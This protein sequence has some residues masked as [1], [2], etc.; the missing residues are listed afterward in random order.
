MPKKLLAFLMLI[1]AVFLC[2]PVFAQSG[3]TSIPGGIRVKLSSG[4]TLQVT[5][6]G[7]SVIHVQ[8][9]HDILNAQKS[10]MVM[11]SNTKAD[12]S[13]T[14][15]QGHVSVKTSAVEAVV[16]LADGSIIF[17]DAA[18][19]LL[20]AATKS[21]FT[22]V[23]NGGETSWQ[24]QQYFTSSPTEA[25][26]GL[27]QHQEGL[28]NYKGY[29]VNLSQYNTDVAIPFMVSNKNYG[30]LWDN[31]SITKVGDVRAYQPL[32]GLKL[33]SKT[34]DEGWLT[35]SYVSLNDSTKVFVQR[36]ES[37]LDYAFL[38]DQDKF[39]AGVKLGDSRVIYEGSLASGYAGV[40]KFHL[41]YSGYIKIWVDGKLVANKWRQAWNPG[42]QIFEVNFQKDKTQPVRIEWI[43]DGG[44]AYLALNWLPPL[45]AKE[46]NEMAFSSEAGDLI[47]YYFIAGANADEVISGY[48]T[49]TGKATL[50]PKWA[51]GFW[52]SRERYKTQDEILSTIKEFRKR[53]I[54]IDNIVLDWSYWK[55]DQW[56]SQEFDETRFPDATGMIKS[57]HND[58]HAHFM[59]SVWP[60]F[61]KGTANYD[62][63]NS[64]GLLYKRNIADARRDWIGKGYE[65]TF[66]DAY[67]PQARAEV[68]S[69]MNKHLYSKG[70]DA[71]WMDASE[72]DLHSNLDVETRKT[73]FTPTYL[74]S[75]TKYFNA[76]A[77]ENAHGIY[78]GQR[79]T[80]PSARVFTLT[81]SA[82]G[83]M[84]RYAAATWSG[85]IASR[86]EDLK[87][88]IPAGLNFSLSGMPYWTMDIGGFSV[89]RRYE[90]P[91]AENLDEW[92]ELNTRW[93]Q[94]GAFVPLFR[95]HG[96]YPFREIYN[97]A[98]EGH[99]AYKSMLYYNKLRYRLMPYIY[100]LAGETYHSN[101]T[102]M[103]GLVMDFGAD[104]A[105]NNI[106]DQ[107]MFGPSLLI[108]PVT[109]YRAVSRKVYLPK[110]ANWYDLYTG[111]LFKGGN[112]ITA[113]APYERMPIFVKQGAIIPFGPEIQYTAE[114][115]DGII[116]VFV[117]TGANGSFSLYEDEGLNYNYEK[118]QFSTIPL[119]YNNASGELTIGARKGS[120]PGISSQRKFK[121]VWVTESSGAS[122]DIDKQQGQTVTYTGK[123]LTIKR[124]Y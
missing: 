83:G 102:L 8:R 13:V 44:E 5:A 53:K 79:G 98:P 48:R 34:G 63:L 85:D 68:W 42:S 17:T 123:L 97:I 72:P 92:R 18:G 12:Y 81:R 64:K 119:K 87:A 116:T 27:G 62:Y 16:S 56:G 26:Y 89:E 57:L 70:I 32:S 77:L 38:K 113:D 21:D 84:Q 29:Q 91:S 120:Y 96:Q 82:Y 76:F 109:D 2:A 51:Y 1:A 108:N 54:P 110:G 121:I 103:R 10:L 55:Q 23:S 114:K 88:Q 111:K 30:I 35:A 25:F 117:Y 112:T 40:H 67:N 4:N 105:V 19:K 73:T 3:Y 122:T 107:Y 22:P 99:K 101:Y 65:S 60:K 59:I 115:T 39:P 9:S 61:Y 20:S 93:Y 124:K 66:Y 28:M 78:E 15:K 69:M 95:Q 86:W 52:Q 90:K 33:I 45:S 50:L 11:D 41:K 118:G 43:P 7:K 94:Y 31:Y 75:S 24:L 104:T 74:G 46:Q 71:W 37:V 47:D 14:K 49:L 6:M 100:S 58:Y 80:N 106:A 36:P